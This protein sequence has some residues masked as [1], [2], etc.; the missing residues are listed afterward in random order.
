MDN[1][2]ALQAWS[3]EDEGKTI[4]RV[5]RLLNQTRKLLN[6]CQQALCGV[7]LMLEARGCDPG[8][9]EEIRAIAARRVTDVLHGV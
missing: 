7:A 1:L 6:D 2:L 4:V 5:G 8:T 9:L 3:P